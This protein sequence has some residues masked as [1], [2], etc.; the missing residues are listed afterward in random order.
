VERCG[1]RHGLALGLLALGGLAC[2]E[3]DE[4]YEEPWMVMPPVGLATSVAF[5]ER[6]S[7]TAYVVDPAEGRL[8]P[9]RVQVGRSPALATRRNGADELVVLCRGERGRP[10]VK[11]EKPSLWLVPG[12][13]RGERR[14]ELEARFTRLAQSEDG[15]HAVAHFGPERGDDDVL[16][17]P[18]ELALID[19]GGPGEAPKATARTL[20]SLG[21]S[22]IGVAFSPELD[23]PGGTRRLA[24]VLS[25]GYVTLLDLTN[26]TRSDIR[27][28]LTLPDDRRELVPAQIS[29]ESKASE[30][31]IFVRADG[32]NDIVALRLVALGAGE[33][34]GDTGNAWKP[35]LSQ[36]GA[37]QGPADMALFAGP[38]GP[39]LLVVS[40]ASR[41]AFVI[42]PRTSR[43]TRIPLEAPAN[44]IVLFE[45]PSPAEPGKVK[46]R[47][48]LAG[49]AT[50]V[51]VLTFLDLDR[52]EELKTRNLDTVS[53]M[54]GTSARRL[55][56][57]RHV[58]FMQTGGSGGLAIVD[59][60][61]RNVAPISSQGFAMLV[62]APAPASKLWI[63]APPGTPSFGRGTGS[64]G[65]N[66]VGFVRTAE[67]AVGTVG[68]VRVDAPVQAVIPIGAPGGAAKLVLVH[69]HAGGH[70]TILDGESPSREAA[71]Q[72]VGFLL[73]DLLQRGVP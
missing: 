30:P 16:F 55:A 66:S 49:L 27:V 1:A 73:T 63:V 2:A 43:T 53:S 72:Q 46:Q 29:F 15:R 47:A 26:P 71:R 59:L 8:R 3:L 39:R 31:T 14:I 45:G 62:E 13:G 40:P 34:A 60:H 9:K 19:L 22:P 61:T 48:L 64:N 24:V 5:V 12:D 17:N 18:N 41:D 38:D 52:I 69:P 65:A 20:R 68:S 4:R 42:D 70:L 67:P 33:S 10:G 37:G 6:A 36:L 25:R 11:P 56:D 50:G 23:L 35:V 21:A 28:P 54:A 32:S 58:V 51:P 7:A 44:H 57:G